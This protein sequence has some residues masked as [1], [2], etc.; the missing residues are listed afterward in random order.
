VRG[1]PRRREKNF[2]QADGG[3]V[4][5]GFAV[6][7]EEL[8]SFEWTCDED[9]GRQSTTFGS[10]AYLRFDERDPGFVRRRVLQGCV[11]GA[12]LS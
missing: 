4:W 1:R 6:G 2:V 8:I 3:G 5:G 9:Q 7:F 11:M 10:C 12:F